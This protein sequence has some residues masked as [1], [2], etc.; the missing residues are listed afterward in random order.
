MKI[1]T[2]ILIPC[3]NEEKTIKKVVFDFKRNVPR[4]KIYV[5]DNNSTDKTYLIAKKAGRNCS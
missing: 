4:S 1:N 3:F 2:A 5:Y